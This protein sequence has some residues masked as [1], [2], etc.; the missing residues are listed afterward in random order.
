MRPAPP[1]PARTH[2]ASLPPSCRA[3]ALDAAVYAEPAR[4]AP[5]RYLAPRAEPPPTHMGFGFGRRICPGRHLAE[6]SLWIV[7]ASVLAVF[8]V[9][10][11][12]DAQGRDVLPEARFTEALTRCVVRLRAECGEADSR[13]RQPSGAVWVCDQ[14][15]VGAGAEACGAA[16][17]SRGFCALWS[18]TTYSER[19]A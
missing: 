1:S 12:K 3:L 5:E 19:R 14:A 7:V 2:V 16:L 13:G 8:D 18:H 6:A 11:A 17:S 9:A 15:E 4:F 10:P